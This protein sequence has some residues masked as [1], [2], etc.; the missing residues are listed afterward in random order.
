LLDET[1]AVRE[2]QVKQSDAAS[3]WIWGALKM[4]GR[5]L[6]ELHQLW[7]RRQYRDQYI[8]T[9]VNAYLAQGGQAIG[10]KAGTAYVDVG[11]VHG[12]R[13][14]ISLLDEAAHHEGWHW[15]RSGGG[16][17]GANQGPVIDSPASAGGF[18]PH[19]MTGRRT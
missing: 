16:R 9:L 11:T 7:I 14:A 13:A 2:I 3:H 17:S 1:N 15:A 5:I 6:H 19:P 10:V 4:P 18:F 8:G 12:Y